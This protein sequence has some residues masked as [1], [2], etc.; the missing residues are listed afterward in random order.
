MRFRSS[1]RPLQFVAPT[2]SGLATVDIVI[3]DKGAKIRGI[4]TTTTPPAPTGVV[5]T[6][7]AEQM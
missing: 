2:F 5:L 1:H 4:Q 3:V 6:F 7:V